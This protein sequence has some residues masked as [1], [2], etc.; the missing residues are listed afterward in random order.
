ML[1]PWEHMCN[2]RDLRLVHVGIRP[3]LFDPMEVARRDQLVQQTLLILGLL[4]EFETKPH[5]VQRDVVAKVL[6]KVQRWMYCSDMLKYEAA[7]LMSKSDPSDDVACVL[8]LHKR[9]IE[10]VMTLLFMASANEA[11]I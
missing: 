2:E 7:I 9:V 1:C 10:K 6:Y 5:L 3:G 11:S 4:L 8:H